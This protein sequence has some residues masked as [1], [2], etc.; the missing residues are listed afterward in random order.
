[1][2]YEVFLLHPRCGHLNSTIGD[3]VTCM[4]KPPDAVRCPTRSNRALRNWEYYLPTESQADKEYFRELED[5]EIS[6]AARKNPQGPSFCRD[7]VARKT[8]PQDLRQMM[9]YLRS[10]RLHEW[11]EAQ[12]DKRDEAEWYL[13]RNSKVEVRKE[14]QI[15][16]G[17]KG[18]REYSEFSLPTTSIATASWNATKVLH[19]TIPPTNSIQGD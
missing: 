5:P 9:G 10:L 18:G 15:V 16:Q 12:R 3:L 1:M 7:C 11:D 8:Q 17:P 6:A 14:Q 4:N 13:R 2:C 19:T